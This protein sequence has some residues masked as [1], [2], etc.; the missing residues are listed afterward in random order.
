MRQEYRNRAGQLIGYTQR[1]GS[2]IEAR[3]PDGRKLASYDPH[4]NE[5]RDVSGRL[6]GTGDTLASF[7]H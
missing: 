2:V 6:I 7:F 1:S 3:S 5:T 4:G